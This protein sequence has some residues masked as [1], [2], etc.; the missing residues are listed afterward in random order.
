MWRSEHRFPPGKFPK[1]LLAQLL[2]R[3][4]EVLAGAW[5]LDSAGGFVWCNFGMSVP[6]SSFKVPF[7]KETLE[8]LLAETHRVALRYEHLRVI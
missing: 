8:L 1:E 5:Q 7:V 4:S 3:N 2:V 6:Y